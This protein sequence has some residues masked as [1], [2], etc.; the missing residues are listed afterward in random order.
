[1]RE[2]DSQRSKVYKADHALDKFSANLPDIADI[3]KFVKRA[4]SMQRMKDAFP[5]AMGGYAPSVKDGRGCRSAHGG[6]WSITMPKWSRKEGIVCH[7][8]AHTIVCREYERGPNKELA[9]HG[10]RFAET[11]LK[12][13]LY[14]MGR[15]AHDALK[16]AFKEHRVRFRPKR[17]RAPLSPE[18][19]AVMAARLAAARLARKPAEPTVTPEMVEGFA[20]KGAA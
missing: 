2:R 1:M 5:R 17:E 9:A 13:V 16:A 6:R 4:W 3:E 12:V 8:L 19:R 20:W 14:C 10:W 15:E 18:Q 7:E 11:Y